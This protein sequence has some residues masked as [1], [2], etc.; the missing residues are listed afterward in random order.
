MEYVLSSA[1]REFAERNHNLVYWFL[2]KKKLDKTEYYDLVIFAYLRAVRR[3]FINR[4]LEKVS[5]STLAWR[6]MENAVISEKRKK[7]T[8]VKSLEE[9]MSYDEKLK[10][11]DTFGH[12]DNFEEKIVY[13]ELLNT[14]K[15]HISIKELRTL[16]KK[17]NGY[18]YADIAK[19]EGISKKGI[20]NR[21]CRARGKLRL[22]LVK[23]GEK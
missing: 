2:I 13:N 4:N 23:G 8:I 20:D 10:L 21:L 7:K 17:A 22:V 11:I 18:K 12:K 1:E 5:F 19:T 9:P 15:P 3:F 14:I 16:R 6:A